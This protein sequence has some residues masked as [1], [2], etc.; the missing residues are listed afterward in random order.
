[1]RLL[2]N[3]GWLGN[4]RE[5]ENVVERA[6]ILAETDVI[7]SHDLPDKLRN[8]QVATTETESFDLTLEELERSHIQSILDKVD[9]DKAKAARVL[10][11]H[12][13][14]L[15]R[16]IQRLKL[17]DSPLPASRSAESAASRGAL[18]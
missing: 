18:G 15:Y 12:L 10:G 9:R 14:T 1:M 11:I 4:V 5:L 16:K 8:T 2:V 6:V 13:S 7:H 17:D 3:Y